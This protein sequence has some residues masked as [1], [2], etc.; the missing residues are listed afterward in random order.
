[1]FFTFGIDEKNARHAADIFIHARAIFGWRW[2]GVRTSGY[3]AFS[4]RC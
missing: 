4:C 2:R 3:R 1:L